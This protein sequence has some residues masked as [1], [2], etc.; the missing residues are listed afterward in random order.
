[1]NYRNN[2]EQKAATMAYRKKITILAAGFRKEIKTIE[3]EITDPTTGKIYGYSFSVGTPSK[4]RRV[5]STGDG[6]NEP[7]EQGYYET[8]GHNIESEGIYV[9]VNGE[10]TKEVTD[11]NEINKVLQL[12]L[13]SEAHEDQIS[14]IEQKL[15]KDAA[16][17]D[18]DE[19]DD[20]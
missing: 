14:E 4:S 5:P 2:S 20:Y 12:V 13:D 16:R 9:M 19:P 7:R 11:P 8:E 3:G 17:N 10:P 6:W 15:L 1:M 18:F